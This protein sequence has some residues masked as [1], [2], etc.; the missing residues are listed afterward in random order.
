LVSVRRLLLMFAARPRSAVNGYT[1]PFAAASV[2]DLLAAAS[3][4]LLPYA[5]GKA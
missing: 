2:A 3:L 1:L 5:T 4:G